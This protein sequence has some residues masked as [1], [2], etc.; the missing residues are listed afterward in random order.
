MEIRG[1]LVSRNIVVFYTYRA[2]STSRFADRHGMRRPHGTQ[3]RSFTIL[4][5][6]FIQ[7]LRV[8]QLAVDEPSTYSCP[9]WFLVG[10]QSTTG[11]PLLI[12]RHSTAITRSLSYGSLLPLGIVIDHD[13]YKSGFDYARL[14]RLSYDLSNVPVE[15]IAIGRT[16][17]NRIPQKGILY[18]IQS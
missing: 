10:L 15:L 17:R 3:L 13:R 11:F 4:S 14:S 9:L 12:P 18:S 7:E 6:L 5:R 16:T 2:V 1:A 8:Q